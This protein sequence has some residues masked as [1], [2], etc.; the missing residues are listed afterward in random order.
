MNFRTTSL[1]YLEKDG[2]YLMLHRT[3]KVNDT[4]EDKWM[5]VGG[6]FEPRESPEDCMRREVFEE[7]GLTVTSWKYCGILT[8]NSDVCPC[9]YI[10]LFKCLDWTGEMIEC[11]E[12]DLEW[13]D[14]SAIPTLNIWRGDLLFLELMEKDVPFFSMKLEYRGNDL[15]AAW[16]NGE[17]YKI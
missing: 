4:N 9:E 5:G 14:K 10:H 1:C 13:V 8:F 6:S 15:V 3:K 7:T 11:N 17:E 2:K 16:L 12:G